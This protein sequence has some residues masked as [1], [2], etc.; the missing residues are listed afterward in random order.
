MK[1]GFREGVGIGA[2]I[3]M[4]A[5]SLIFFWGNVLMYFL[6]VISLI[7][8]SIPFVLSIIKKQSINGIEMKEFNENIEFRDKNDISNTDL[9]PNYIKI[10]SKRLSHKVFN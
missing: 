10:S 9:D 7:V 1:I 6:L 5:S 8:I 4:A 2:G 3:L